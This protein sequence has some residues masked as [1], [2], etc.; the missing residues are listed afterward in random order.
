[1]QQSSR[2]RFQ[3]SRMRQPT[4]YILAT[5]PYGTLYIGVTSD[6]V[7]RIWEHRTNAA[8]GFTRRYEVHRLVYFEQFRSMTEAIEREK[9]L[10]K[11]RRAWK[12]ALVEKANS[13][14]RD[15]WPE[16]SQ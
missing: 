1:M 11:W 6:L 15:L 16:I 8:E 14:W 7:K 13:D 3:G 5:K 2:H 4:V 9:E 12:I 10:K